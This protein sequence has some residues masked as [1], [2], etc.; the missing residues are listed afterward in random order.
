MCFHLILF[1]HRMNSS[2]ISSPLLKERKC[3]LENYHDLVRVRSS[4]IHEKQTKAVYSFSAENIG[5]INEILS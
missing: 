4:Q 5:A 1:K 3:S 2:Q